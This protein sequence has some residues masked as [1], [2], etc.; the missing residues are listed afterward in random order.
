MFGSLLLSSFS[1]RRLRGVGLVVRV[2]FVIPEFFFR[3]LEGKTKAGTENTNKGTM[4]K[5]RERVSTPPCVSQLGRR[6]GGQ[7][8]AAVAFVQVARGAR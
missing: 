7:L 5:K 4:L 2:F 6:R 8:H 1:R 3:V